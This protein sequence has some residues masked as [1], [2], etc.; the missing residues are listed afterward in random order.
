[1]A[2]I[3]KW[4]LKCVAQ[5]EIIQFRKEAI[6]QVKQRERKREREE[7][8]KERERDKQRKSEIWCQAYLQWLS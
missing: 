1:M 3:F 7:E 8:E 4:A 5:L 2:K 6:Q